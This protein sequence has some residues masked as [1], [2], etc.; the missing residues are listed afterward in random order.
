MNEKSILPVLKASSNKLFA[1]LR[2]VR[3][4][5]FDRDGLREAVLELYPG[6]D[7]KS[8]FRG[9]V[10]PTLR[11]LGLIIGYEQ[12]IRLSANGMLVVTAVDRSES[13]GLRALRAIL[14]EIDQAT[15]CFV[16]QLKQGGAMPIKEFQ[17]AQASRVEAPSRKQSFERVR[18]WT[19]YLLYAGLICAKNEFLQ[20]HSSNVRQAYT[21]LDPTSK[22]DFFKH[23]LLAGYKDLVQHQLGIRSIDIEALR[24]RVALMAYEAESAVVTEKQFDTLLRA[25]PHITSEYTITFGRSMGPEEKLFTLGGKYYQTISI[26]FAGGEMA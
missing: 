2:C 25:L 16:E 8:V 5:P 10:V 18:D 1:L 11:R 3:E 26:R 21:D 13:E 15:G 22:T 12:S 19:A 14:L 9:M 23:F 7:E 24:Q 20:V 4:H 6:R 17:K